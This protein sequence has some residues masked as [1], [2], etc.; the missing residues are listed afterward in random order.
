MYILVKDS[1]D[2]GHAILTVAHS[3]VA[4][5]REFKDDPYFKDWIE[6]SF[7]KVVCKVNQKEFDRAKTFE[8]GIIMTESALDN[9]EISIIFCPRPNDEWPDPIKWYKLYK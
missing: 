4:C 3:A 5:C 8:K 6:N 9:E 1:V 7:R 2:L